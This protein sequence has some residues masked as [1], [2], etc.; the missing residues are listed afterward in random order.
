MRKVPPG[1]RCELSHATENCARTSGSG[2]VWVLSGP[3]YGS[4]SGVASDTG[5]RPKASPELK[6]DAV[7]RRPKMFASPALGAH[8]VRAFRDQSREGQCQ[9]HDC[10]ARSRTRAMLEGLHVTRISVRGFAVASATAVTA[11]GAV[12]GVASG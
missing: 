5:A 3:A 8:R 12:V 9:G 10:A 4:D 6:T 1:T 7:V 11:V 2:R